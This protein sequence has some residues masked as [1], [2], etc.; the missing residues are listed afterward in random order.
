MGGRPRAKLGRV[1]S[2]LA[3]SS[4]QPRHPRPQPRRDKSGS[5][6]VLKDTSLLLRRSLGA[7]PEG[8]P[9]H[10]PPGA[11]GLLLSVVT[12]H[13]GTAAC[14][15]PAAPPGGRPSSSRPATGHPP[16][17]G[18]SHPRSPKEGRP[19]GPTSCCFRRLL[20]ASSFFA[21]AS[22]T[23]RGSARWASVRCPCQTPTP[24]CS[25]E[26]S[27]VAG[28]GPPSPK[29]Q[30][31]PLLPTLSR[32]ADCGTRPPGEANDRICDPTA[33]PV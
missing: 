18:P 22:F 16:W 24:A 7:P 1:T 31:G 5:H 32:P 6:K 30:E 21:R 9:E 11:L 33:D 28:G 26:C 27:R 25:S 13:S 15:A 2:H 20:T 8:R 19:W 17:S 12:W 29:E 4:L 10:F 23:L 3:L 14:A